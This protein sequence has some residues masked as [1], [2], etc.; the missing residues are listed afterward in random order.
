MKFIFRFLVKASVSHF[1]DVAGARC[2]IWSATGASAVIPPDGG[3]I[4]TRSPANES[5]GRF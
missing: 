5:Y 1:L 3:E 4:R 2:C